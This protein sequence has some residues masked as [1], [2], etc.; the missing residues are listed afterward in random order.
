MS[1]ERFHNAIAQTLRPDR[2]DLMYLTVS[3]STGRN[4]LTVKKDNEDLQLHNF[5]ASQDAED[6]QLFYKLTN[7]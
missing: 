6:I 5:N 7:P 4:V 3:S 1:E 2:L